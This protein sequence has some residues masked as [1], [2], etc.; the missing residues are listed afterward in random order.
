MKPLVLGSGQEV[1]NDQCVRIDWPDGSLIQGTLN[2]SEDGCTML[3]FGPEG[4]S[5]W[6]VVATANTWLPFV[7]RGSVSLVAS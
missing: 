6:I 3:K 2:I 4:A 7:A 5:H 1:A